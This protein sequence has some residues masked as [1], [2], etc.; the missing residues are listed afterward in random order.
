M[1]NE[2]A[3]TFLDRLIGF[4]E[5]P[6][7]TYSSALCKRCHTV[8][9]GKSVT[10]QSLRRKLSPCIICRLS[11]RLSQAVS[12]RNR[13]LSASSLR[14]CASPK[15]KSAHPDIQV[16]FPV[17]LAPDS[18]VRFD[19]FRE[20]LRVC[21]QSHTACNHRGSTTDLP[22]RVID[23]GDGA[24]DI[25][26]LS[27]FSPEDRENYRTDYIA[28]SYCWGNLPEEETRAFCTSL[29]N[30]GERFE[31]GFDLE[32]LPQT[33][34]D[35]IT[36][37]RKL[38]KRYLW[39]DCLCITQHGDSDSEDWKREVRKMEAVF[40]NA[41][42]TIAA[43]SAKD[44]AE[45]FL[46]RPPAQ[47]PD[48]QFIRVNSA[49]HGRIYVSAT[50]DTF[51]EDV[52]NGVLSQR[53]WALQERALSRRTIHFTANQ[54]YFECGDGVRC[55]TLSHMRNS[56]ALFMGDPYFPESLNLRTGQEKIR[57]FQT[58]FETYSQLGITRLT[59]RALAISGLEQRLATT[60]RTK[61]GYGVFEKYLHRSLLWQRPEPAKLKRIS[62]S[63]DMEVP[64]WSW[65]AYDGKIKYLNIDS[66]F[67]EWSEDVRLVGNTLQAQVRRFKNCTMGRDDD[68]NYLL[69]DKKGRIT[70][71]W[72]RYDGKRRHTR[73][74][75]CVV[76]GRQDMAR[77]PPSRSASNMKL[78]YYVL[79]VTAIQSEE[80]Q[81]YR[82]VGV[83]C[84]PSDYILF[85]EGGIEETIV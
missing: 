33:F 19:L 79:V 39:V 51:R 85:R 29:E 57:L 25:V 43:T 75:K 1:D 13:F 21:D 2:F 62:Y 48:L 81:A 80:R 17:L 60:F 36:L 14:I 68:G 49:V 12:D 74:H 38:G 69:M 35:A 72:L 41:Y 46:G 84:V 70:T 27:A 76:I 50:A 26:R 30:I 7:S 65:M 20:W 53:A 82:R 23:V 78:E 22:T 5:L 18:P 28:L 31:Q 61:C 47:T 77:G 83:G 73:K 37:T 67:V 10:M 16:G 8:N 34:R 11:P 52:E 54:A 58:M 66:D 6:K 24:G 42:C 63:G 3:Q 64:S 44:P 4:D 32:K 55:E 40:R 45:G 15:T 59:D 56:K 9:L 71:G